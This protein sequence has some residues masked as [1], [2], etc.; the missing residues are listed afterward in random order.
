MSLFILGKYNENKNINSFN[1]FSLVF[2]HRSL[3]KFSKHIIYFI[4]VII[5]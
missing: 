1:S 3:K 2:I 4:L 5:K